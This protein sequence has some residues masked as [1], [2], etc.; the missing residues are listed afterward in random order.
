MGGE[1]DKETK[2][3]DVDLSY[4]MAADSLFKPKPPYM[5]AYKYIQRAPGGF[6]AS[7]YISA[8]LSFSFSLSLFPFLS[9]SFSFSFSFFFLL[10]L[11]LSLSYL[12]GPKRDKK[13]YKRRERR[14]LLRIQPI[15]LQP[16][17][18]YIDRSI[19]FPPGILLLGYY[20]TSTWHY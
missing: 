14:Q 9:L 19:P 17:N 1:R 5:Y 12:S 18:T 15:N 10:S 3:V 11:S 6:S 20:M 16:N 8:H 13:N 7:L 4:R 2:N